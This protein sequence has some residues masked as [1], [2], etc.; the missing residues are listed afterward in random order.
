MKTV[1]ANLFLWLVVKPTYHLG[2]LLKNTCPPPLYDV[3]I[4]LSSIAWDTGMTGWLGRWAGD[5]QYFDPFE[6]W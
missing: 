5:V 3:G 2:G 6:N 4:F 1:L